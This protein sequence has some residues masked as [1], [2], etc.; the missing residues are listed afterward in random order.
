M[1]AWGYVFLAYGIVWGAL[2]LYLFSLKRRF[3]RAETELAQ[4][5]SADEWP[6]HAKK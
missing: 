3:R 2:L 1:S 4:L 6:S 5:R